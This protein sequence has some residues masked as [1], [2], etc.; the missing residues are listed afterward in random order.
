MEIQE[1]INALMEKEEFRA[2]FEKVACPQ[3]VVELFGKNGV[4]VPLEV[5]QELFEPAVPDEVELTE[6]SL[7]DVAGGAVIGATVGAAIGNGIFYGA[8]YLGGRLAGWSKKK[9]AKYAKSCSK[10]GTS[11][12]SMIGA[13]LPF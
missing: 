6:E 4:E 10:F 3:D 8:G 9:S 12:G 2:A 11:F 1:K 13:F 7:A 5:A